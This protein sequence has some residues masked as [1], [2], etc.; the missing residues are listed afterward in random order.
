[1]ARRPVPRRGGPAPHGAPPPRGPRPGRRPPPPPP[2]KKADPTVLFGLIFA[3]A[4][5]LIIGGIVMMKDSDSGI[6]TKP[7]NP[8]LAGGGDRAGTGPTDDLPDGVRPNEPMETEPKEPKKALSDEDLLGGP[9]EDDGGAPPEGFKPD[10]GTGREETRRP[11]ASPHRTKNWPEIAAALRELDHVESTSAADR[12]T[13]DRLVATLTDFSETRGASDAKTKLIEIGRPAVPLML[14][15]VAD[16]KFTSTE[17]K[18]IGNLIE[19]ALFDIFGTRGQFHRLSPMTSE[20]AAYEQAFKY[21]FIR[22][23]QRKNFPDDKFRDAP[24]EDED[25]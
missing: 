3:G 1:M 25:G 10:D 13:I 24:E 19:Q 17:E 16:Y 2:R 9:A 7:D 23:E 11:M 15:A 18:S 22:W 21:H 20:E 6:E 5:V 12:A 4:A 8:Y 14:K